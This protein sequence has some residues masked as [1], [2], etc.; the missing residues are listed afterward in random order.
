MLFNLWMKRLLVICDVSSMTCPK[1][2]QM[3]RARSHAVACFVT[4]FW[5]AMALYTTLKLMNQKERKKQR[6]NERK[7]ERNEQTEEQTK[8]QSAPQIQCRKI[9]NTLPCGFLRRSHPLAH[10]R[11]F[12]A[13]HGTC[14]DPVSKRGSVW[15]KA[16]SSA[17]TAER[18]SVTRTD[19]DWLD[20]GDSVAKMVFKWDV[21]GW[22]T[23]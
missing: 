19:M 3:V 16:D 2:I 1:W 17:S 9:R 21:D 5:C 13:S 6:T 20:E 18:A 8:T 11:V 10:S 22:G 15:H 7:K 12:Q 4:P 14:S 23:H